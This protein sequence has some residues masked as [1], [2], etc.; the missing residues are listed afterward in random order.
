MSGYG[1]CS[2]VFMT[3]LGRY[4]PTGTNVFR[5]FQLTNFMTLVLYFRGVGGGGGER[6]NGTKRANFKYVITRRKLILTM[7]VSF[8]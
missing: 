5:K 2:N 6:I 1:Y 3:I 7:Q 4:L 8:F